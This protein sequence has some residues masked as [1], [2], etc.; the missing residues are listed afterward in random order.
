[1]KITIDYAGIGEIL[2]SREMA[3]AID[4]LADDIAAGVRDGIADPDIAA[5]VGVESYTTDR[6][7]AAVTIAHPAGLAIQA[8]H[9]ALTRAAAAA[10]LD[11]KAR[12]S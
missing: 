10:G 5:A 6:A 7:A 2:K 4:D 8:K 9:G 3:A 1:M 12:T 11:V